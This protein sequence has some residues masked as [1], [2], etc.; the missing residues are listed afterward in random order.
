M[1]RDSDKR[2]RRNVGLRPVGDR[3]DG[4]VKSQTLNDLTRGMPIS[5]SA[6]IRDRRQ[7]LTS[8][9]SAVFEAARD[10]LTASRSCSAKA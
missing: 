3:E 1:E 7:M 2:T 10:D 4:A 5:T 8:M 6:A 9:V